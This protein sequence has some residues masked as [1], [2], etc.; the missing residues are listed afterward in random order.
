MEAQFLPFG[1]I[2][3]DGAA[4]IDIDASACVGAN[5]AV[6]EGLD[7]LE[8]LFCKWLL[9]TESRPPL[10]RLIVHEVRYL[11]CTKQTCHASIWEIAP[12]LGC[13]AVSLRR[14]N[15]L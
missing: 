7:S 9:D 3:V 10:F 2:T 12:G 11:T 13:K 15:G 8:Y 4:G 14:R 1:G 5:G 6:F